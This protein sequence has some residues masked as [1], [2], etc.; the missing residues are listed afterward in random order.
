MC[1]CVS[2]SVQGRAT[3]PTV[4]RNSGECRFVSVWEQEMFH[5]QSQITHNFF[6]SLITFHP[7]AYHTNT[8]PHTHTLE[9]LN[10]HHHHHQANIA[11][12]HLVNYY[13]YYFFVSFTSPAACIYLTRYLFILLEID[14]SPIDQWFAEIA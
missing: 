8:H 11:L 3:N 13:Y 12:S 6:F 1:N 2:G 9:V 7:F 4:K 5:N 10:P 14:H